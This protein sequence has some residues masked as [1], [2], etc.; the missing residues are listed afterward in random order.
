[1]TEIMAHAG[2]TDVVK[3]DERKI[4]N[5]EYRYW[6]TRMMQASAQN[7]ALNFNGEVKI[8]NEEYRYLLRQQIELS[9]IKLERQEDYVKKPQLL[10]VVEAEKVF[11]K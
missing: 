5:E 8:S 7:L 3:A 9:E 10:R 4:S 2:I 11:M 1:M 6:L